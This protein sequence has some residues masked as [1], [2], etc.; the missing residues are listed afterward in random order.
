MNQIA[1]LDTLHPGAPAATGAGDFAAL[2]DRIAEGAS[3]RDR[4]RRLP[5]DIIDLIRQARLGAVRLSVEDGGA[6]STNRDL[7]GLIVRLGE[8][9]PNVAHILRNHFSFVERYVRNNRGEKI[10]KWRKAVAEGAIFGLAY[11]ELETKAVGNREVSTTL[12]PEAG[13]YRLNGTKYYSTGSLYADYVLVR[14]VTDDGT[15]ASA[16]VPVGREGLELVDDWDG[17]GQ[18]L[19]GTGTTYLRNVRVSADE[20]V[21]DSE[22]RFLTQPYVGAVPQLVLTAINA[23]IVQA[24]LRDAAA[25]VRRRER[26][27]FHASAERPADDPLLQQTVGQIASSAFAANAIVLAAA[28]ALDQL[29]IVR[30][31]GKPDFDATHEASLRAS[32]AKVVV[33][34]LAIRAAGLL[35]DV[36]GASATKQTFNLDRHWRNSRTLASHNPAAYKARAIGDHAINGTPLPV[37]GFF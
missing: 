33:D 21:F 6:G 27:F 12:T 4:E 7:F 30:E 19:T 37:G 16:I 35:L 13:G 5:H 10:D 36:G 31:T 25:L 18:R 1:G 9:D 11:G 28:D 3:E 20:V 14:A 29:D 22:G 2:L 8:A 24:T 17:F 23:G 26:S 34:E 32:Q 15:Q